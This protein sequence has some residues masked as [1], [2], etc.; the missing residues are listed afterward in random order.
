MAQ[1]IYTCVEGLLADVEF[2]LNMGDWPLV[3][4]SWGE[5]R[6]PVFSWCGSTDTFDIVLPQ[7]DVTRST[8]IGNRESNPDLLASLVSTDL[9]DAA[10]HSI[11]KMNGV[12]V[13]YSGGVSEAIAQ[14]FCGARPD[15]CA[16]N[17]S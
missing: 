5:S 9:W 10:Q 1:G 14:G 11:R 13:L 3:S 7:W 6:I 17:A 8:I 4:K 15:N 2:L 12:L 16:D